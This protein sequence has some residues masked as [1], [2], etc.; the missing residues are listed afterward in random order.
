MA[1]SEFD[2]AG[3]YVEIKNLV[4]Q[5]VLFTPLEY[6]ESMTTAFSDNKDAVRADVVVFDGDDV[7]EH[8]DSLIFQ[9][10]L[11]AALKK[12][13][14]Y[15]PS[16]ERDPVTGVV[17]EYVT[18]TSRRVLG[19]IAKGE[20]KKG[21]SEPYVLGKPSPEQVALAAAWAKDNPI[22]APV[23]VQSAQY[24]TDV[25]GATINVAPADVKTPTPE[26]DPFTAKPQA[27][28]AATGYGSVEEDPFATS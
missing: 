3:D 16:I 15:Q 9:G 14:S 4:G 24:L 5:L 1:K 10:A 6:I 12:K 21:Q 13:L 23:K 17:T 11:I 26:Q 22:G 2:V 7:N 28:P 8:P 27:A 19:V 20:A 18:T 25:N